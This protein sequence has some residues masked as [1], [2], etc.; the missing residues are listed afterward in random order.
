MLKITEQKLAKTKKRISDEWERFAKKKKHIQQLKRKTLKS[1]KAMIAHEKSLTTA[2]ISA[3]W[4]EYQEEK[5]VLSYKQPYKGF[6]YVKSMYGSLFKPQ[7]YDKPEYFPFAEHSQKIYKAKDGY[8]T[9]ELDDL[10]PKILNEKRVTGVLVVFQTLDENDNVAYVS[11]F[12][13][14]GEM[15]RIERTNKSVYDYVVQRLTLGDSRITD[16]TFIYIRVVYAKT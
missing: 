12:I 2:R 13:N 10:I 7:G 4:S 11:N 15:R 8:D 16:L 1:K 9:D 5:S 6:T 14:K 3:F